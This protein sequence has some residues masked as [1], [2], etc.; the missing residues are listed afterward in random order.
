MIN[1]CSHVC[2]VI[3][4]LVEISAVLSGLVFEVLI[5]VNAN[6]WPGVLTALEIAMPVPLEETML[7]C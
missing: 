1:I 4:V 5:G 6:V 3:D 2:V 7:S